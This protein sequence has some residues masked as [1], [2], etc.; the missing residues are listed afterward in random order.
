MSENASPYADGRYLFITA[1]T[2]RAKEL[3]AG[4]RPTIPYADGNFDPIEVAIEEL[5][6][7]K[8]SVRRRLESTGEYQYFTEF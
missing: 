4:G 5:Q 7:G 1:V 8:L 2:R 6:K 3:A